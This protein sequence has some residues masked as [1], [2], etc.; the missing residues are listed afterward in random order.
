MADIG[1][2]DVVDIIG[3]FGLYHVLVLTVALLRAIPIAWTYMMSPLIAPDI[4]HECSAPPGLNKTLWRSFAQPDECTAFPLQTI[5][6]GIIFYEPENGTLRQPCEFGWVYDT[7]H[8]G[9]TATSEWNLVCRDSWMRSGVQS[10][11]MAGSFSGVTIFGK[12]SDAFGRKKTFYVGVLIAALVGVAGTFASSLL[13]FNVCRFVIAGCAA[14]L[15]AAIVTLFMEVMPNTDRVLM[16][17]GFGIG[18]VIPM[19]LIGFMSW[20]FQNFRLMQLALGLSFLLVVPF[21]P[22]IEESPK[23]LLAKNRV[24]EAAKCIDRILRRSGRSASDMTRTMVRIAAQAQRHPEKSQPTLGDLLR[25][26]TLRINAVSIFTLWFCES[27]TYY[28]IM[29]NAHKFPGTPQLNYALSASAEIPAALIGIWVCRRIGRRIS[30]IVPILLS[31][32]S[33]SLV[34]FFIPR[35]ATWPNLLAMMW[36]RFLLKSQNFTQWIAVHENFPTPLRSTGFALCH[37]F[38]RCGAAMAPF[39]VDLGRTTHSAIPHIVFFISA[40]IECV[41]LQWLPETLDEPL[42][43]TLEDLEEVCKKKNEN[44]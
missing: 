40:A 7:K 11:I 14:G 26:S 31:V 32:V 16:N 19:A 15:T 44:K 30:Q 10:T 29:L 21:Y 38:S 37:M 41:C 5:F 42:P 23:W 2:C 12:L 13:W 25:L 1:P 17:V 39:V 43:D 33:L 18:Y 22:Y 28:H 36:I 8:F 9:P 27:I 3:R 34:L 20:M 4:P 35:L 6:N 24:D